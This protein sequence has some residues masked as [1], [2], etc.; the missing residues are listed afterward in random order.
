M[1][2][3]KTADEIALLREG[4]VILARLL[5]D[6]QAMV[7]PGTTTGELE[8]FAIERIRR[9]GGRPAFKGL[10]MPDGVLYPTALCTSLNDEVVHHAAIPSRA[11]K[12][13]DILKIDAGLEY[14]IGRAGA[15]KNVFSKDGG[16]YTDAALTVI[17]GD[18]DVNIRRLVETSRDCLAAGIARV[19]PGNTL[20]DIGAAIETL[21]RSRGFSVVRDLVGHGVGHE[22]HEEPLVPNYVVRDGSIDN[23]KL[24]AGMVLAIEPMINLG[25]HAVMPGDDGFSYVTEDGSLSAQFEHTVL[26]TE[27]GYEILTLV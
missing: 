20:R 17:V 7:M 14:P 5:R 9:E 10:A 1:I 2:R 25:G 8:E 19:K 27:T 22:Y 3:I 6:L 21:A 23:I 16:Y 26:V 15:V 12:N 4:G 13:G 24:K 18:A 11:L